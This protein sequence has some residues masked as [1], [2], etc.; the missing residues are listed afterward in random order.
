LKRFEF[1]KEKIY[2]LHF[3]VLLSPMVGSLT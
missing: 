3:R 1:Q 2:Q